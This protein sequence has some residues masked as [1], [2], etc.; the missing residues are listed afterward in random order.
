M[1][2]RGK[3]VL[4]HRAATCSFSLDGPVLR[5]IRPR[6]GPSSCDSGRTFLDVN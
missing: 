6:P 3:M 4:H 5:A 1:I 2:G